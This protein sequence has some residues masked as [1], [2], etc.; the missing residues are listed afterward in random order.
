MNH[1]NSRHERNEVN[2]QYWTKR[3]IISQAVIVIWVIVALSTSGAVASLLWVAFGANIAVRSVVLA[4]RANLS[5]LRRN[6]YRASILVGVAFIATAGYQTAE[7][8]DGATAYNQCVSELVQ[9]ADNNSSFPLATACFKLSHSQAYKAG[10][11]AGSIEGQ[12]AAKQI[13]N[14]D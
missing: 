8:L 12:Q 11:Q 13:E 10:Q 14:G 3:W 6:V 1:P 5:L 4:R 2:H 9:E 7:V